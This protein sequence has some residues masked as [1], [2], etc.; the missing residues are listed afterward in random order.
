MAIYHQTEGDSLKTTWPKWSWLVLENE[1]TT[2]DWDLD[3]KVE[4]IVQINIGDIPIHLK[5]YQF[6]AK[7]SWVNKDQCFAVVIKRAT[8][9][10]LK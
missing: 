7:S 5:I 10:S 4:N 2:N 3:G 1:F 8:N 9:V 6:P